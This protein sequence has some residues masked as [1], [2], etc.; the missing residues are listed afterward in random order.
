ML[1]RDLSRNHQ[2]LEE[3]LQ[4]ATCEF[5]AQVFQEAVERGDPL[6]DVHP[7]AAL[8]ALGEYQYLL[9]L[10]QQTHFRTVAVGEELFWLVQRRPKWTSPIAEGKA[11]HIEFWLRRFQIFPALND[12]IHVSVRRLPV[13]FRLPKPE[14]VSRVSFVAGGFIDGV[15][16]DWTSTPLY[17][18]TALLDPGKRWESV[19]SVLISATAAG[20]AIVVLPELTVD[21]EVRQRIREWLREQDKASS[22]ALVV[23]GSF[24]E[25][26]GTPP[27]HRNV[28]YVYDGTGQEVL[29]HTKLRPMRTK[30]RSGDIVDE[31]VTGGSEVTLF[32]AWFGLIGVATC[33]DFCEIGSVPVAKLWGIVGPAMMLVPSMGE[34]TTNIAH[35]ARARELHLQHGTYTIVASQHPELSDALGLSWIANLAAEKHPVLEGSLPWLT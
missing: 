26:S 4:R 29:R 23:A 10:G 31:G 27:K 12:G 21:A 14:T 22:L 5:Q 24:H 16:P 11:G 35:A 8:R 30:K 32:Y 19:Q 2:I 1:W 15:F 33:L 25:H 9:D 13:E 17:R 28:A 34:E 18:C 3:G 7:F 6:P 20:A